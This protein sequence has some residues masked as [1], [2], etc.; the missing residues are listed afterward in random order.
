V[1]PARQSTE[2]ALGTTLKNEAGS[3]VGGPHARLRRALVALQVALSL[4]LLIG[5]GLFIRS[6]HNLTTIDTGYDTAQLLSF[7]VDPILNGYEKERAHHLRETLLERIRATP[8]VNAA[9]FAGQALFTGGSWNS[10]ITIEGYTPDRGER[11][12]ALNNQISPGYFETM[13]MRLLAGRNVEA[14]DLRPA[15]LDANGRPGPQA[16]VIVN[17]TFAQRFLRGGPTLG[18][19]IGLGGDPG[20]PTP[21]EIVGVVSDAKYNNVRDE[22]RPQMFFPYRNGTNARLVVYVRTALPLDPTFDALRRVMHDID[23]NLPLYGMERFQARIDRSLTN[24]RLVCSLSTVFGALATLLAMTGLYGVMAYSVTRRT[25][26]IG[27]R[28]AMGARAGQVAWLVLRDA[29]LL[30]AIGVAIGLPAAWFA[31]R[32]IEAQLY[33][34]APT[35][36]VVMAAAVLGLTAVAGAAGFIPAWRA[37]RVNPVIALRCE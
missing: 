23:P 37:T 11:T 14:Q 21:T 7:S 20:T 5:A 27:L 31:S 24:E 8:G 25:R 1:L 22:V 32:Y 30:V 10:R 13:G 6:L 17:Q 9:A 12:I 19:H 2:P 28:M 34:V 35:D 18:R 26:E 16:V 15:P 3:V 29:L 36:P 33:A 4:L